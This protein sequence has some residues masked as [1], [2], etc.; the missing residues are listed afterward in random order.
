MTPLIISLD[1]VQTQGKQNGQLHL[2][3]LMTNEMNPKLV[4]YPY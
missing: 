3:E 2:S 4:L 1:P